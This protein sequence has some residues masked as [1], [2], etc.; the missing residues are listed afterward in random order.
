MITRLLATTAIVGLL[1]TGSA[2]AEAHM[3][4]VFD[5]EAAMEAPMATDGFFAADN[6]NQ[7]LASNLIG[8]TI[9]TSAAERGEAI[10]DVNDVILS[11]NG[12][13]IAAIVGVGGFLGMGEKDVAV[14]FNKLSYQTGEDGERWLTGEFTQESLEAA[15]EFD[16]TIFAST[17][18]EMMAETEVENDAV[19]TDE[20][21][22]EADVE[23][24]DGVNDQLTETA[25][26]EPAADAEMTEETVAI[27]DAEEKPMAADNA[28]MTAENVPAD[29]ATP[30]E[31][32]QPAVVAED[33][34]DYSQEL[35]VPVN[36]A[37]IEASTLLGYSVLGSDGDRLGEIDD[38]ILNAEGQVD[39]VIVDV[40]GFF[41]IGEKPVALGFDDLQLMRD[42]ADAEW[43][44]VQ[45]AFTE[46]ELEAQPAYTEEAYTADPEA[47][48][49]RR[50]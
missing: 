6:A 50:Q 17:D 42:S 28:E 46:E 11:P 5:N 22:A 40:G 21:V 32:G 31:T 14:E 33:E 12:D 30:A 29:D 39:A 8:S 27:Q 34:T 38:F 37:K 43:T 16:R 47:S 25:E 45:V 20:T 24:A 35:L 36:A 2:F 26:V 18:R 15:P 9:Y 7:I 19:M 13:V 4:P 44:A 10:G 1:S 48:V 41:G 49:L 3:K 23:T